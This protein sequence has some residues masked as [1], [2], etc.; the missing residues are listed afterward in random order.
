[1]SVKPSH[2]ERVSRFMDGEAEGSIDW[3][4]QDESAQACWRRFHIIRSAISDTNATHLTEDVSHRVMQALE[5]EPT[6]FNPQPLIR[7]TSPKSHSFFKPV[8]G[9][10]I[11]ATVAAVTVLSFQSIYSNGEAQLQISE[12]NVENVVN[13]A[14]INQN[15]LVSP[16][17]VELAESRIAN[18]IAE[19]NLD[20]YLLE[21]MEQ[22]GSGSVQGML[23]Y[24]R[25]AGYD[26][27]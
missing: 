27:N 9:L 16:A 4:C 17:H 20:S 2:A 11:A 14:A 21:H 15:M 26:K 25:L 13:Q 3:L 22:S 5:E 10:A 6:I 1:M 12:A 19:D 18:D 7:S 23:P 8:A 24:V